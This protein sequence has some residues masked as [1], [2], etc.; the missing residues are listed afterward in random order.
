MA[1]ND[2]DNNWNTTDIFSFSFVSDYIIVETN[3]TRSKRGDFLNITFNLSTLTNHNPYANLSFPN[4]SIRILQLHNESTNG[5]YKTNYTFAKYDPPGSYMINISNSTNYRNTTNVTLN[6]NITIT[7]ESTKMDALRR[8]ISRVNRDVYTFGRAYYASDNS[9]VNST[10]MNATYEVSGSPTLLGTNNTNSSGEWM[11][12]FRFTYPINITYVV[13]INDTNNNGGR[14]NTIITFTDVPLFVKF[15][16]AYKIGDSK[17]NDV[18]RLGTATLWNFTVGSSTDNTKMDS[19]NLTRAYICSYDQAQYVNGIFSSLIHVG[20]KRNL[21]YLN[22]SNFASDNYY[23]TELRQTVAGAS[24]L[25]AFGKGTCDD[26]ENRLASVSG[27]TIPN[28]PIGSYPLGSLTA[29][30]VE[31]LLSYDWLALNGSDRFTSGTNKLCI[32]NTKTTEGNKPLIDVK[33]C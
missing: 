18:W 14:N 28:F 27:Q 11:F 5:L 10:Q 26:V 4:N 29:S 20:D 24:T 32:E 12:T 15:T 25:L 2:T 17:T 21:D 33:G 16:T 7:L 19:S 23:R 9:S 1:A 22:F 13:A 30:R 6:N 8:L 31:I 3:T